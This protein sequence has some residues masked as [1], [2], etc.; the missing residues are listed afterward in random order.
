MPLH[1]E[2]VLHSFPSRIIFVFKSLS[3]VLRPWIA[4]YRGISKENL[5][6]YCAQ[7]NFLRNTKEEDRARRAAAI[8]T[9]TL[10]N[11]EEEPCTISFI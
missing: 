4:T 10:T 2:P 6:L 1:G 3:G 8:A 5:Y 7:Y 11:I 9:S